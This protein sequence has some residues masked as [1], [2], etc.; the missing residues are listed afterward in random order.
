MAWKTPTVSE[1]M[2]HVPLEA[3]TITIG[4]S[5]WY[6]WLA[7][8]MHCSFR[9]AHPSG[10]FTA[11][12]ERKQRGQQYWIAYR[13]AHGKLYKAYLGK[14]EVLSEDRLCAAAHTLACTVCS[15]AEDT[16]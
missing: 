12:K 13:R 16:S 9:F 8:D 5:A 1:G 4:S 10:D 3:I 11:R 2:L 14:P 7:D 15:H 6:T